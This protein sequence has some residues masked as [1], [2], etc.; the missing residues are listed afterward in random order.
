M[1][2]IQKEVIKA[3]KLNKWPENKAQRVYKKAVSIL[4]NIILYLNLCINICVC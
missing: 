1:K 2:E 4:K 3:I